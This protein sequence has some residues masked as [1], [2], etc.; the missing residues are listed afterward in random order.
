MAYLGELQGAGSEPLCGLVEARWTEERLLWGY[1]EQTGEARVWRR[2]TVGSDQ[3][4]DLAAQ[5]VAANYSLAQHLGGVHG[6]VRQAEERAK[7]AE[8][9][10]GGLAGE[11]GRLHAV[12]DQMK[13]RH[14]VL[15]VPFNAILTPF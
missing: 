3:S 4:Q 15:Q 12:V 10:M 6:H 5:A 9:R 7:G 2:Q 1:G 11:V 8:S 13:A 14:D